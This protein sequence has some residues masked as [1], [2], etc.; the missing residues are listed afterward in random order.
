MARKK[1]DRVRDLE[2]N[3]MGN[4]LRQSLIGLGYHEPPTVSL[5]AVI[6]AIEHNTGKKITK[7]RLYNVLESPDVTPATLQMLADGLRVSVA[8]LMAGRTG[9]KSRNPS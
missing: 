4:V 9:K 2:G 1:E 8:E 7:Q 3:H 5:R 6:A